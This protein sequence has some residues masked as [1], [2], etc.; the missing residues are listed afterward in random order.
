MKVYQQFLLLVLA[1]FLASC[2]N[3]EKDPNQRH[4]DDPAEPALPATCS[5][6]DTRKGLTACGHRD[7]GL[8]TQTCVDNTW[9]DT[10]QCDMQCA[11]NWRNMRIRLLDFSNIPDRNLSQQ[12][13]GFVDQAI[14]RLQNTLKVRH[15][16]MPLK[17]NQASCVDID[18]AQSWRTNGFDDTDFAVFLDN[19]ND[20]CNA[21]TLAWATACDWD[22]AGRPIAMRLNMCDRFTS[23][24]EPVTDVDTLEH[25]MIHGL[26]FSPRHYDDYVGCDGERLTDV[27]ATTRLATN[28][29]GEVYQEV[30]TG[31]AV[32]WAQNYF[33]CDS[34]TGVPLED[35]GARGTASAHWEQ[36][37]FTHET[38]S[39]AQYGPTKLSG[40]TLAFLEDTGWYQPIYD[41]AGDLYLGKGQGCGFIDAGSPQEYS[42]DY[43]GDLDSHGCLP[44]GIHRGLCTIVDYSGEILPEPFRH[45]GNGDQQGPEVTEFFPFRTQPAGFTSVGFHHAC[46]DV[47]GATLLP[48]NFGEV[49]GDESRCFTGID[50]FSGARTGLCYESVCRD[51]HLA[52]V[53]EGVEYICPQEGGSMGIPFQNVE[54]ICP[55]FARICQ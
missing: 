44:D 25:E 17:L 14:E 4:L 37:I 26:G 1:I 22:Q 39:S 47:R 33:G 40:L 18:I 7:V 52:V 19:T 46:T 48:R 10:D 32:T 31:R 11:G 49:W 54:L 6:N 42:F 35:D 45:F 36:R 50:Q 3:S 24:P 16:D 5:N 38:M 41:R 12:M 55:Q 28:Q 23:S 13:L 34:L 8:L 43:C 20:S 30:T 53:Y 29:F 2:G 9:V 27:E 51:D 15:S 21:G